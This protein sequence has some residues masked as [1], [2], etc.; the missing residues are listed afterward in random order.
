[1]LVPAK[2]RDEY[3]P[4]YFLES[5]QRNQPAFVPLVGARVAEVRGVE[6]APEDADTPRQGRMCPAP[7][8]TYL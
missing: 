1:M 2:I 7:S 4:V 5:P 8:T 6:R 3:F